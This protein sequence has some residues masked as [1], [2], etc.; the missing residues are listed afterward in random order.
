MMMMRRL[1]NPE[2]MYYTI[3]EKLNG[4]IVGRSEVATDNKAN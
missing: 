2:K 4:E 3:H 1:M